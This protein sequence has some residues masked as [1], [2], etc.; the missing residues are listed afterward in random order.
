MVEGGVSSVTHPSKPIGVCWQGA[1]AR[2]ERGQLSWY[3]AANGPRVRIGPALLLGADRSERVLGSRIHAGVTSG[4]ESIS[5]CAAPPPPF[6]FHPMTS[7]TRL[8]TRW[9]RA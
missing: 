9:L 6:L 4:L 7:S 8:H 2:P 3:E 5:R 1:E